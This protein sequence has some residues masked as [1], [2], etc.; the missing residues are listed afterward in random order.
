MSERLDEAAFELRAIR[1]DREASETPEQRM[2][3]TNPRAWQRADEMMRAIDSGALID[4]Y[5]SAACTDN[6]GRVIEWKDFD[7]GGPDPWQPQ[8][9]RCTLCDEWSADEC[10]N[11]KD[12]ICGPCV[13]QAQVA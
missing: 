13:A 11:R 6:C 10:G 7:E 2:H 8:G 12:R 9:F 4:G 5:N 1:E 3:R